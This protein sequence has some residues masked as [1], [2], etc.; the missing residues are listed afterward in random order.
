MHMAFVS[1]V[2]PWHLHRISV[3]AGHLGGKLWSHS[4][5]HM[6]YT[7]WTKMNNI[8]HLCSIRFV[9]TMLQ[10][11]LKQNPSSAG[12]TWK[13]YASAGR[14]YGVTTVWS[15]LSSLCV[16]IRCFNADRVTS[17]FRAASL[18]RLNRRFAIHTPRHRVW[19]IVT[20]LRRFCKHPRPGDWRKGRIWKLFIAKQ[21]GWL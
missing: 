20:V 11:Q 2:H 12:E 1:F 3:S 7:L 19:E 5:P 4:E 6:S 14:K 18:H 15:P 8:H 17:R 10:F 21:A 9:Q 16:A 13:N